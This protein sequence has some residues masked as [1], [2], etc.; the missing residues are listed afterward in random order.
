M[1]DTPADVT[2]RPV[3]PDDVNA[4][5]DLRLEALR[6]Q[7]LAFGADYEENLAHPREFW[8]NRIAPKEG[9]CSMIYVAEA[10]NTLVG[11]TGIRA[12]EGRKQDHVAWVWGVY[13]REGWRGHRIGDRL[14]NACTE[15]GA[16]QGL[17]YAKLGVLTSN[18]PAICCYVRCGFTVFALDPEVIAWEGKYY[19]ELLMA[20]RL[21]SQ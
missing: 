6:T 17:R 3:T 2:I 13:V 15:W 9:S 18:T 12:A 11:L 21:W 8:V 16:L 20:K 5:R 19:D 7:P 4:F 10:G 14:V 1:N